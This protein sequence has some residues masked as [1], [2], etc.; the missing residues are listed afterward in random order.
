MT[1]ETTANA[2]TRRCL[3]IIEILAGRVLDGFSNKELADALGAPPPTI[4][5]DLATLAA[6]GWVQR[7]ETG[8]WSLSAKPLQVAQAYSNH[9]ERT[10]MRIAELNRRI[11]A[12]A[13]ALGDQQ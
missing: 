2:A 1:M 13:L 7:L 12:G 3:R 8:R 10:T 6:V 4:S 9:L 5:R 11:A